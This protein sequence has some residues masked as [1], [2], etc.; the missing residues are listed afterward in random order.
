M[1]PKTPPPDGTPPEDLLLDIEEALK[2]PHPLSF[3]ML[4]S[5]LASAM[6]KRAIP[7]FGGETHERLPTPEEF[8]TMLLEGENPVA[9]ALARGLA[10]LSGN[11]LLTHRVRR[12]LT[13]RKSPIPRWLRKLDLVH[14]YRAISITDVLGDG[15]NVVVGVQLPGGREMVIVAYVD[16]NM[17]TAVKDAF[18]LPAPIDELT[19]QW[20]SLDEA[21]ETAMSDLDL[22]DARAKLTEAIATGAMTYPPF[23]TDTWPM[24]RPLTEWILAKMPS[25]GSGYQRPEFRDDELATIT[26]EFFS[27]RHGR[28]LDDE[29]HRQLF[30]SILWFGTDY[31]PGDPLRW[32][33]PSVEILLM[34]FIPR[35]VLAPADYL[36]RL[37]DLLRTF[38]HY[39]HETRGIPA[40]A[41][42]ATLD[43]I[44]DLT[45]E[46]LETIRRPRERGGAAI[47]EAMGFPSDA[48]AD[49]DDWGRLEGESIEEFMLRHLA[50]QVGGPEELDTITDEPL[51]DET[52]DLSD[53][54]EDIV[55]RVQEIA[56]LIDDGTAAMFDTEI[57]TACRRLLADV[58]RADPAIFRRAA[59]V[60]TAAAA[61]IWVI[62]RANEAFQH[63]G[64]RV[65]DMMAHFGLTGSVSQR[66]AT[67]LK[68]L[69]HDTYRDGYSL[70]NPDLLTSYTRHQI[71]ELRDRYRAQLDAERNPF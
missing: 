67:F 31:G 17:G 15:E 14:P 62:G 32:S 53:V 70:G 48:E 27:S 20:K 43:V 7:P 28:E 39:A 68:A 10:E 45:P 71:I 4:T 35:K 63:Y 24:A 3:L 65:Q 38:V 49:G 50:A 36:S 40:A 8:S 9:D 5:S 58:A 30:E 44:D 1:N 23:E 2:E 26:E 12:E 47:L 56:A 21:E 61:L 66:A 69:G 59:K 54:A 19:D 34:D 51:P 60:T 52:L 37:P 18:V 29:D 11:D 33:P 6:D 46:Y 42:R 55:P 64:L 57:R 16:H 41:T 13:A 22:A 25:G